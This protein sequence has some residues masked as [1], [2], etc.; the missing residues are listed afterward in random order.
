MKTGVV[1]AI[2]YVAKFCP[3]MYRNNRMKL[4]SSPRIGVCTMASVG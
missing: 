1:I 4:L 2:F 3:S